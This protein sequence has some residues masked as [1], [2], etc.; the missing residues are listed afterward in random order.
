[1]GCV[2]Q[3]AVERLSPDQLSSRDGAR[4]KTRFA[5]GTG[6]LAFRVGQQLPKAIVEWR[7]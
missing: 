4:S 6:P 2:E 3:R 5:P 1:M 7:G